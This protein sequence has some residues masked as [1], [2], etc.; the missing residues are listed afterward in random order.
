MRVLSEPVVQFLL[1]GAA[2]FALH[3]AL[4][5]RALSGAGPAIVVDDELA[6]WIAASQRRQLGQPPTEDELRGAIARHVRDQVLLAEARRRGLELGDTV[7]DR[8]LIQKMDFLLEGG[9]A[10]TDEQLEAYLAAHEDRYAAPIRVE[11]IHRFFSARRPSP[12][13]DAREALDSGDGGDPF[14]LGGAFSG[15]VD[16]VRQELGLRM[17]LADVEPGRWT[18]PHESAYGWHLIRVDSRED[19]GV[20]RLLHVRAE[21]TRD[22]LLAEKERAR[23]EAV[24]DLVDAADVRI[25][26]DLAAAIESAR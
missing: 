6:T 18:G 4:G 1:L 11:V 15:P 9:G 16:R 14:P 5:G 8:R 20:R 25:T 3:G 24:A 21:V 22:W 17:D 13:H 23:A 26:A 19:G 7:I 10:P 12:E 2:L